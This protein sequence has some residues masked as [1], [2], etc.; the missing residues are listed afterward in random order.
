MKVGTKLIL[1]ATALVVALAVGTAWTA[2]ATDETEGRRQW[3]GPGMR[4]QAGPPDMQEALDLTDEQVSQ[5]RALRFE[6]AKSRIKTS[7]DARL[8]RLELEELLQAEEPNPATI[9]K[10]LRA[11]SDA[12]YTALKN[13]VE[14]RL[15]MRQI[16]TPEQL[17]KMEGMK[18]RFRRH[19]MGQRGFGRRG[20]HG[21]HG[22]VGFGPGGPGR[23][24]RRGFGPSA[25]EPDEFGPK[26]EPVFEPELDLETMRELEEPAP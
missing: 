22:G 21:R 26:F 11:L 25:F 12:H 5:L 10:T 18:R 6:G 23:G 16:L 1:L 17:K 7:A 19:R 15:A 20:E 24:E 9:D 13:R 3:R 8:K 14:Q 4:G 2:D